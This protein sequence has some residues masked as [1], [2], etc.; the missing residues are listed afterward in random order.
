MRDAAS[1]SVAD[2]AVADTAVADT[3]VADLRLPILRILTCGSVDDGKSTLLGR[4]L[5]DAGILADDAVEA[6]ER[7]SKALG[8]AG[9]KLDFSLLAD[10]LMAER[11][12]GITID[13]AYRYFAT[14]RRKFIIADA[15]G[16]EQYTRNMVTGASNSDLAIILVDA[17]K[18]L[19]TQ[20]RRHT[21]IVHLL[22]IRHV[23]V[24]VNKMD[25]VDYDEG[26]FINIADAF[27]TLASALDG[28]HA[29]IVPVAAVDGDN[30]VERSQGMSWYKGQTLLDL[31]ETLDIENAD[32]ERPLRL[33]V[34]WICRPHLNFRGYAGSLASG[35]IAAGDPVVVLPSG[36]RSRIAS[37]ITAEKGRTAAGAGEPVI[38]TLADELDVGRGDM[39]CGAKDPIEVADRLFAK[40]VWLGEQQMLRGR[41]YELRLGPQSALVQ[42]GACKY[43]I[44]VEDLRQVPGRTLGLNEIGVC[45]LAV[46]RQIAFEPYT[47]SREN[48]GFILIDRLT[49]ATVGAGMIDFALRRS[50]NIHWQS[51]DIDKSARTRLKQQQPCCIWFTGLSGSGKSTVANALEQRLHA[52]DVHTYLLDGDNVR[53]GLNR[54]LGFTE[55]DR[56]ENIRRVSEVARL[57]VDA[58]LVTLVS[59]ISPFIAE[60]QSARELLA[61]GEFIEVFVDT[62]LAV[63]EARDPKGLYRKARQGLIKNFTG[64]DQPYESPPAPEIHLD[65]TT[66]SVDELVEALIADLERRGIF[67]A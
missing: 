59:F 44:D 40:I 1:S 15:P 56:V 38:V 42:I 8:K 6:L 31:L 61:A 46:D 17:R 57:M 29:S 53:H 67:S 3:A 20:T 5:Y 13:V 4:M 7:D 51:V 30:I 43:K 9:D 28:L 18:G 12:Q 22:G 49:Y 62:P 45:E 41:S 32:E 33:P 52:M 37:V 36:Q 14:K 34:Q 26:R 47:V 63:C 65:T 11:E 64:I 2:T 48:G 27:N 23:I 25:L 58:G 16:H 39:I 60:R 55:A 10:G 35:R 50:H 24:A 54:D 19:L 21:Y 66:K